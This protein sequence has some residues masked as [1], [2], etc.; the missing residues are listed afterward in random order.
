MCRCFEPLLRQ[1]NLYVRVLGFGGVLDGRKVYTGSGRMSLH[2]VFG[3]SYYW[4]LCY[5]MLVVG[6]QAVYKRVREGR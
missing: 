3:G 6:V 2:L 4:H 5:S 1:V